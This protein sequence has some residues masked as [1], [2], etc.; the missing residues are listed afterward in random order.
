MG[1]EILYGAGAASSRGTDLGNHSLPPEILQSGNGRRFKRQENYSS[2]RHDIAETKE[3]MKVIGK[4]GPSSAPWTGLR[5][6]AS[7]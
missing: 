6:T 4:G 5:A 3:H 2:E 1:I 7:S